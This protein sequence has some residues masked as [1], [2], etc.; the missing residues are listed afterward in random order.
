MSPPGQSAPAP[1][2]DQK[3]PNVVSIVPTA[4]LIAFSGTRAS[5]AR[6]SDP[7]HDHE[8]ERGGGP[9]GRERNAPL[10]APEGE[11]DERDLIPSRKTPLNESVKPYQ[12][13]PA[14]SSRAAVP[15]SSTSCANAASRRAAP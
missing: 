12:S 8:H 6:T 7:D 13:R 2:T 9:G 11:D 10:R 15:A 5:G 4:N 1:S 14:R 3:M